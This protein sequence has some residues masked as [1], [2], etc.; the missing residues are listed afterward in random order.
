M[1][2][3][4]K[5]W[6]KRRH[7]EIVNS[8]AFYPAIIVIVFLVLSL[9]SIMFDFSEEGMQIKSHLQWLR[10]RDASTA[11]SIISSITAGII[12]L[13]VFSFSMVMIVL[14]Q[15]A[16][17]LSNRILDRL[18]GSRFQQMVLGTY[19]GTIV[20][21]LFLLSM[22]RDIDSGVQI[23]AFS[24]YFL[25]LLTIVDIFLF[26]YFLHYIT[27]SIKY[28]VIIHRI[29]NETKSSMERSCKLKE[30]PPETISFESE[31]LVTAAESGI[32]VGFDK[33]ILMRIGND[34]DC[35]LS[36]MQF[37]GT[38]V[39]KGLPV[40][41][42]NKKLPAEIMMEIQKQMYLQPSESIRENFFFGFRQL[43]ELALKALSPGINDPGTAIE[44][45]RA[46]FQLYAYR[47][48]WFPENAIKNQEFQV[49]VI[50]KELTFEKIFN[51][52]IYPIW[53]YG[54]QDR[55]IQ[56]ELNHLLAVFLTIAPCEKSAETLLQEVKLQMN[57]LYSEHNPLKK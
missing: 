6:I 8:I 36:L 2:T 23:P 43:T 51:D 17:Q 7:N 14:N 26:I 11:R 22:V 39:L 53:D 35:I 9:L 34:N 12:T 46:L 33:R 37:P 16:S 18:I 20:Y 28:E 1:W 31:C 3:N 15:T 49:R 24:T 52:T 41:K 30:S 25:I 29:L 27:Q 44:S 54:K 40:V 5:I 57:D 45:L 47:V 19:V 42:A 32:Y 50:L 38:F 13:T 48:I 21:A 4:I 56:N 10:L 55:L